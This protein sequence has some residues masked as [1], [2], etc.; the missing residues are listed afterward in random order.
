MH[1]WQVWRERRT[2]LRRWF[3]NTGFEPPQ[4]ELLRSKARATIPQWLAAVAALNERRSG[5]SDRSVDFRLLAGWFA[6]TT[7]DDD[8][9][10]LA[11]AAFALNPAR[12]S[13]INTMPDAG[14]PELPASTPWADAPP[15]RIHPR[16]REYGEATPRGALPRVQVRDQERRLLAAQ[17]REQHA[18]I[19]AARKR[20]ASGQLT[21][22]SVLGP[23]DTPTFLVPEFAGRGARF[24][25]I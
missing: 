21:R 8:S 12:H 14:T 7:N 1:N 17:F 18:Q 22:P 10:R 4:A 6:A 20:L 5:R 9:H 3:V 24:R 15:L 23:L 19:E 16:L 2:G 25:L 11:R 13:S